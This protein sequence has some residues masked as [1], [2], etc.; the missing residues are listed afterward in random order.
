MKVKVIQQ[1]MYAGHDQMPGTVLEVQR[2]EG[3][4]FAHRGIASIV[5]TVKP[6]LSQASETAKPLQEVFKKTLK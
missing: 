1:F 2:G 5:K 3:L 4:E 6:E